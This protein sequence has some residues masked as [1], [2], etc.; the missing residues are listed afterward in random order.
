VSPRIEIPDHLSSET[1]AA[2]RNLI[3][4]CNAEE[5]LDLPLHA[6]SGPTGE[7]ILAYSGEVLVG[8]AVAE[9]TSESEICLC[10]DLAQR[11]RGVGRALLQ[12]AIDLSARR[13]RALHR[14]PS[15][16]SRRAFS[17]G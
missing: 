3:A 9:G 2:A 4:R 5:G 15:W 12:A 10:V 7:T 14:E 1:A 6:S 13:G 17:A 11:R 16:P 8:L